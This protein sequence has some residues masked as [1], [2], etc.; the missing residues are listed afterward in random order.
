MTIT[1]TILVAN[2]KDL[3]RMGERNREKDTQSSQGTLL[4]EQELLEEVE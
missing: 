3:N 4:M 2:W 1:K